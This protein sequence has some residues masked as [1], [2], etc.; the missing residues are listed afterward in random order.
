MPVT[1]IGMNYPAVLA[2][3]VAGFAFGAVW[4]MTLARPWMA[5]LGKSEAEIKAGASSVVYVV[6]AIAQLVMAYFLA[7]LTGH[8]SAGGVPTAATGLTTAFFVWFAFVLTTMAVNHGFQGA[9]RM[10]TLI[11]GLHWLGVLLI[12][13]LV[14]GLFG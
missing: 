9:K 1:G 6:T 10:L 13:G 7:G 8:L 5:A 12:Q 14:I 2:A 11:D 3:A 4:Y